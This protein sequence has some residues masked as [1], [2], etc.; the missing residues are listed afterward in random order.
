M[1]TVS[2]LG[3]GA[4]GQAVAAA[5]LGAAHEVTVW[6]RTPGRAD[7]LVARGARRA[8]GAAEAVASGD[9]VL[10][11]V[12]DTT[13]AREVLDVAGDAVRGRTIVNLV[14]GTPAEARA[15][16]AQLDGRGARALDGVMMA[17]P[18]MIGT[19]DATIL[20]GGDPDAFERHETTL[21]D[22][23]GNSSFL[24]PDVGLPALYDAGLLTLLYATMTGW[25]QAFGL[26]VEN[27]VAA[28]EFLPHA[29]AW[30][31]NVVAADDAAAVAEAVDRRE[32]PDVI[33]SPVALNAAALRLLVQVHDESGV[34][35]GLVRA[36]SALADARVAAGHGAD[37]Y[38]SLVEAIRR[39]APH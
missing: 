9:L 30:F 23:A 12:L 25:L 33:P 17:V 32:Y 21:R 5:L 28:R 35:S 1:A 3:L 29:A 4:M 24:G 11:T 8:A 31:R 6:N 16:A 2:V 27:G 20:Y 37:G 26:V 19:A 22:V 15:I 10:L 18:S 39:R 14:T 7:A 34:D 38:S 13:A 36:I